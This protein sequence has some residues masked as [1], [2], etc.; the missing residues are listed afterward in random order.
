MPKVCAMCG[1][2]GLSPAFAF[3]GRLIGVP[4]G[5]ARSVKWA[6]AD[7]DNYPQAY[8]QGLYARISLSF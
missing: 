3:V 4:E 8:A 2:F 1:N 7:F 5:T 6:I